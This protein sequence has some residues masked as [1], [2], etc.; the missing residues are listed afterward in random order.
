MVPIHYSCFNLVFF[1]TCTFH[2]SW[3]RL[4]ILGRLTQHRQIYSLF[5][6]KKRKYFK[7]ELT[8]NINLIEA[9][10]WGVI[11][12]SSLPKRREISMD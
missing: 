11:A 10:L 2:F 4:G 7:I 8:W 3:V 12:A 1:L 9:F 5:W 6:M